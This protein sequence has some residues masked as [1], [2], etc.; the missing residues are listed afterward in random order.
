MSKRIFIF[1]FL[2]GFFSIAVTFIYVDDYNRSRDWELKS[3]TGFIRELI[4]YNEFPNEELLVIM[5][6]GDYILITENELWA[7][8][9][10]S[11]AYEDQV[12][13][14]IEYQTNSK[15]RTRATDI[16]VV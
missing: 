14:Y 10:L 7:Y 12:E 3:K 8:G 4:L 6:N 2:I 1:L 9:Y 16:R 13:V 11:I 5:D 15:G